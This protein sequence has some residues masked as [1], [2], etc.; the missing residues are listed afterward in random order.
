MLLVVV[1]GCWLFV[2]APSSAVNEGQGRSPGR[3]ESSGGCPSSSRLSRSVQWDV[4]AALSSRAGCQS[5]P[6]SWGAPELH[7]M[8]PEQ[9]CCCSLCPLPSQGSPGRQTASSGLPR[10]P[11]HHSEGNFFFSFS[12]SEGSLVLTSCKQRTLLLSQPSFPAPSSVTPTLPCPRSR[13]LPGVHCREMEPG[14]LR[15]GSG[16]A[17]AEAALVLSCPEGSRGTQSSGVPGG[18]SVP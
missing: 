18:Y 1:V 8:S 12:C 6:G 10:F 3:W 16:A 11:L 15:G 5:P 13:P 14:H 2:A 4:K 7:S 9:G 17:P